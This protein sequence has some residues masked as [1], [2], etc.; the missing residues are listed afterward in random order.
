LIGVHVGGIGSDGRNYST[1]FHKSMWLD[2][3]LPTIKQFQDKYGKGSRENN[4][5]EYFKNKCEKLWEKYSKNLE[6]R[7]VQRDILEQRR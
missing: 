1:M 7:K 5:N 2:F 6:E 3:I 4:Y